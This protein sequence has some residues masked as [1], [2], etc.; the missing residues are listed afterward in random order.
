MI[1]LVAL[2]LLVSGESPTNGA[3]SPALL[4]R[5]VN[6]RYEAQYAYQLH[7]EDDASGTAADSRDARGFRTG[8]ALARKASPSAYWGAS[9]SFFRDASAEN[10]RRLT[11]L[12][13]R[14]AYKILD[15]VI[16]GLALGR[17]EGLNEPASGESSKAVMPVVQP[18]LAVKT[19]WYELAYAQRAVAVTQDLGGGEERRAWYHERTYLARSF[20]NQGH[21]L[22]LQYQRNPLP[23]CC[24]ASETSQALV[25]ASWTATA[26]EIAALHW[27]KQ[28][29]ANA[30]NGA[31]LTYRL[32]PTPGLGV[33]AHVSHVRATE[34]RAT[35]LGMALDIGL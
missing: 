35:A 32:E 23:E 16:L 1:G 11:D 19:E 14:G 8:L 24:L 33:A 13:L 28:G 25:T 26:F 17:R 30:A 5:I 31:K 2:S 7:D 29:D 20:P 4:H 10:S 34:A 21:A 22:S 27:T 15:K 12:T 9:F 3:G 18:A 6:A